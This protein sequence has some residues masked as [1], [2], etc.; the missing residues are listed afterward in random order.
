MKHFALVTT[1]IVGSLCTF[2]QGATELE[3]LR[4]RCAEQERQITQL[5]TKI[6]NLNSLLER[7][8]H[9]ALQQPKVN[10]TPL[11]PGTQ[12]KGATTYKVKKGDTISKIAKQHKVSS[13]SIVRA[14]KL[15][16]AGRI[17]IGQ[18]LTIPA[19][20]GANLISQPSPQPIAKAIP[21]ETTPTKQP[22][23]TSTK[24]EKTKQEVKQNTKPYTVKSGDT[25][26]RI[27]RRTGV[28][29]ANILK[30][31][32]G[33]KPNKLAVGQ[34]LQLTKTASSAATTAPVTKQAVV[35]PQESKAQSTKKTLTAQKA[36][37]TTAS[38][39]AKTAKS[40]A[41]PP[42]TQS[43]PVKHAPK[44]S[45]V[46]AVKVDKQMTFGEFCSAHG[47]TVEQVN[48]LNGHALTKSQYLA[49]GSE[50][51]VPANQH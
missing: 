45:S 40:T 16:N 51:Y 50:L 42:K 17:V 18:N 47:T 29:V 44:I 49:K 4:T 3:T 43:Q 41:T 24:P 33:I 8:Q 31:N 2:A 23:T 35:K 7:N 25:L 48:E 9:Q 26:Y 6:D 13:E 5:E 38:Q 19:T 32:P 15:A 22:H 36:Q 20:T 21:V 46:R 1:T 14:N 12:A 27:S 11:K 34:T 28:S 30:A 10:T 37:T 39:P